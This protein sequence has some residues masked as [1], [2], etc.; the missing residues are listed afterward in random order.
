MRFATLKQVRILVSAGEASGD[1]YAAALV[2][3]LAAKVPHARFFGCG[4]PGLRQAGVEAVVRTEELAVVGLFEVLRHIP[5]IHGLFRKLVAAARQRRPDIAILTDAPDFHLRLAER[6]RSMGVPVIYYVAPQIWAWRGWRIAK[7]R[8]LVEQLLVIF[9]FEEPYFSARGIETT[10]VGHPLAEIAAARSSRPEF[11]R[12]HSLDPASKLVALLPGSRKGEAGRHL[13][14]LQEA[15]ERLVRSGVRQFVLPAAPTAGGKFFRRRWRGPAIRVVDGQAQDCI[16]HSDVAL[17]A[18]GTAT[19]ET[20]ML[21]TPMVTFYK[22][23]WP[24]YLLA[25]LLVDVPHYSMVNLLANRPVVAEYMQHEC[26]GEK[27]ADAAARLLYTE[28]ERCKMIEEFRHLRTLLH[29]ETPAAEHA[30]T[31]IC[32]RFALAAS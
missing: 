28:T 1:R 16:A 14:A 18:S 15:A 20:A 24:S 31:A 7:I 32:E 9:P 2:R 22:L 27:L 12:R 29:T 11:F 17:V 3:S 13:P 30:A 10:F 23:A 6:L 21:G 8:R 25:R 5:R 26:T 4:G 19:I